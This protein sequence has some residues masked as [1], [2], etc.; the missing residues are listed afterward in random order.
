MNRDEIHKK[1]G[2]VVERDGYYLQ[3]V[4]PDTGIV[5]WSRSIYD[6]W[7]TRDKAAAWQVAWMMRGYLWLFNPILGEKRPFRPRGRYGAWAD[8]LTGS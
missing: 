5:S 2:M 6:A 4:N 7:R 1:T 3:A 8:E